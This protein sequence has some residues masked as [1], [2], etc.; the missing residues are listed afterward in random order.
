M[1]VGNMN[2]S[3]DLITVHVNVEI[4]A[5][6]IQAVVENAKKIAGPDDKGVYHIDTADMLSEMISKFL[7]EKDFENY[8]KN[9]KNM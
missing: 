6:S 3:Q 7:L 2:E 8:A 1:M 9:I 4:T 5:A